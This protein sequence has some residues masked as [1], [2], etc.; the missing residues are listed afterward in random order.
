MA[1]GVKVEGAAKAPRL[2]AVAHQSRQYGHR[3]PSE[4]IQ[5]AASLSLVVAQA[6]GEKMIPAKA[7]C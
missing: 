2:R 3:W 1:K 5:D 4:L 7:T 6:G